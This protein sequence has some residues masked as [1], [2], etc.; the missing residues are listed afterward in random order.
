MASFVYSIGAEQIALQSVIDWVADTTI[1]VMLVDS[2]YDDTVADQDDDFVDEPSGADALA[3]EIETATN[4]NGGDGGSSRVALASAAIARDDG[5]NRV[6]FT[7]N[8]FTAPGWAN[9]GGA[10]NRTIESAI[11]HKRG[12]TDDTDAPLI[13]HLDVATL[14][15]NGSGV[16]LTFTVDGVFYLQT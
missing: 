4:Y 12:A 15:T 13:V 5:T 16:N 2:G 10:A 6:R 9:L 7:A 1:L 3:N 11:V 14:T 8:D